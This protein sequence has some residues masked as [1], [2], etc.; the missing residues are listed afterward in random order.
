MYPNVISSPKIF[1]VIDLGE[2]ILRE[3]QVEDVPDFFNYYS[4]PQVN[5]YILA[6]IPRDLEEA[7]QELVYWRGVFYSN[8]GI[9]FG[10]AKKS[11]NQ[12]IGSIGFS[13]I[14]SY[15]HRIE[16]SYDLSRHYWQRGIMTD[17]IKAVLNYAFSKMRVNRIEAYTAADNIPSKNLLLKCGFKL[18]GTL[19]EHRY[20]KNGY[21]D[22][23]MFSIL[24][25]EFSSEAPIAI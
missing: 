19:R 20:H 24:K 13:G 7:R 9:Y 2:Y 16:L 3:Q 11:D 22:A 15:H 10:I 18:E 5:R 6:S 17:A 12:L 14:N 25:R 4:D 8:D 21:V 1:P 23:L